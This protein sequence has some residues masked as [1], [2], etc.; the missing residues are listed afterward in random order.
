MSNF[1]LII[2]LFLAQGI[3][4]YMKEWRF[5]HDQRRHCSLDQKGSKIRCKRVGFPVQPMA[6]CQGPCS[7]PTSCQGPCS[8]PISHSSSSFS[9]FQHSS[10]CFLSVIG[11]SPCGRLANNNNNNN[12]DNNFAE[13]CSSSAN[14]FPSENV[15]AEPSFHEDGGVQQPNQGF[16]QEYSPKQ[17]QEHFV[18]LVGQQ[19]G[20]LPEPVAQNEC[21]GQS[22]KSSVGKQFDEAVPV[23]AIPPTTQQQSIAVG[24]ANNGIPSQV[25]QRNEDSKA[26]Y[27]CNNELKQAMKDAY[28]SAGVCCARKDCPGAGRFHCCNTQR[29]ANLI[30]AHCEQRFGVTFEV[31][32][33][34]RDFSLHSH[35][36]ENYLCKISDGESRIAAFASARGVCLADGSPANTNNGTIP[37]M[38]GRGATTTTTTT[39]EGEEEQQQRE[40]ERCGGEQQRG[41]ELDEDYHLAEEGSGRDGTKNS[42]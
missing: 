21:S 34:L 27:C 9:T 1:S 20:Q 16:E 23:A 8:S 30:Q 28:E 4:E 17:Q 15:G 42:E 14:C 38:C 32:V 3:A 2:L 37:A 41:P 29:L 22:C 31:I 11:P 6:S 18:P 40:G 36:Y 39:T 19:N 7:S 12:N 25:C 24:S 13:G 5:L 33:G 26:P 35:Y 10:P